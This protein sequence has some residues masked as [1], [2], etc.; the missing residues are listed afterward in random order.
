MFDEKQLYQRNE[1]LKTKTNRVMAIDLN[2]NY[3]GWSIVDWKSSNE[4]NVV[5]HGVYS[6]KL[7][8]DKQEELNK[9]HL[10]SDDKRKIYLTNKRKHEVM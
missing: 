8:N 3:I 1:T 6:L 5:K 4:F 2:P 7:L 9:L 10:P